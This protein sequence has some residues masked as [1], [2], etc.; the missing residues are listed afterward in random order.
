MSM[1][2]RIR[3]SF[4]YL[5]KNG[6]KHLVEKIKAHD[7]HWTG[8]HAEYEAQKDDIPAYAILHFT[9]DYEDSV[10]VVD[11]IED[12]NMNGVTSNAVYDATKI[13]THDISELT[14]NPTYVDLG[15]WVSGG[16]LEK[17]GIVQFSKIFIVKAGVPAGTVI[18]SGLPTPAMLTEIPASWDDYTAKGGF[19]LNLAGEI[20]VWSEVTVDTICRINL[21]YV[22][23]NS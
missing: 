7:V 4:K 9:D 22:K 8:T 19:F 16:L 14:W 18:C 17:G 10:G 21:A 2:D 20:S 23:A 11:V 3:D 15:T 6:L 1:L 12:N 5:D 13:I